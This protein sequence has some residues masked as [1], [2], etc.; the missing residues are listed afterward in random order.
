MIA[1]VFSYFNA[2][3]DVNLT[4]IITVDAFTRLIDA[5]FI[6]FIVCVSLLTSVYGGTTVSFFLKAWCS[7]QEL[8]SFCLLAVLILF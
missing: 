3:F 1:A 2:L 6:I 5:V 7:T 8:L 4:S